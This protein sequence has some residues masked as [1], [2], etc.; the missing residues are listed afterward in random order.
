MD[1]ACHGHDACYED[2]K[3]K[4]ARK[5]K[6]LIKAEC[7]C[8]HTLIK[9][10]QTWK[11]DKAAVAAADPEARRVADDIVAAMPAKCAA[12][13]IA[14]IFL[15]HRKAPAPAADDVGSVLG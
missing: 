14:G 3:S 9:T 1:E 4:N 6:E 2:A 10:L 12:Y 7:A 15:P 5:S 11:K 8:D 13:V